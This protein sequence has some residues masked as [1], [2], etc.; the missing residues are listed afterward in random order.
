VDAL[1]SGP[2]GQS[3]SVR[4]PH[5][6]E[7]G[8]TQAAGAICV[9]EGTA[10]TKEPADEP[11]PRGGYLPTYDSSCSTLS[12]PVSRSARCSATFAL[13]LTRCGAG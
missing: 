9:G 12:M 6:R 4:Y 13:L 8:G 3:R 5:P 10:M 11:E 7:R 2:R 1:S